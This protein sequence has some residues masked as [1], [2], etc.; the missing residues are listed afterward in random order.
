MSLDGK[1]FVTLN[2]R[3][4]HVF[5]LDL[6]YVEQIYYRFIVIMTIRTTNYSAR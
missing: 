5:Y 4:I 1:I 2:D 3:H 6:L